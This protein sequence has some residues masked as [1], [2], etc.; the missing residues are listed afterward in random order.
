[1][2]SS[3]DDLDTSNKSPSNLN[4]QALKDDISHFKMVDEKK[5]EASLRQDIVKKDTENV[6]ATL[7]AILQKP[8]VEINT[9]LVKFLEKRWKDNQGTFLAYTSIPTAPSTQLCCMV[10][11]YLAKNIKEKSALVFLMPTIKYTKDAISQ[12]DLEKMPLE[13]VVRFYIT[14]TDNQSLI[15]IELLGYLSITSDRSSALDIYTNP[16]IL[17]KLNA[18]ERRRLRYH[19][20][21]TEDIISSFD[22]Y[23]Q[24]IEAGSSLYGAIEKLREGL[25]RGGEHGLQGGTGNEAGVFA[26]TA[27][28]QFREYWRLLTGTRDEVNANAAEKA[29]FADPDFKKIMNDKILNPK[30]SGECV[31][32]LRTDLQLILQKDNKDSEDKKSNRERFTA[33]ELSADKNKALQ[34]A[35][36]DKFTQAGKDLSSAV[37]SAAK[38]KLQYQGRD[39]LFLNVRQIKSM[40]SP[41]AISS[42][43]DVILILK[44]LTEEEIIA[45][46]SDGQE[47]KD[48]SSSELRSFK[49]NILQ[50]IKDINGLFTILLN[51]GDQQI[52]PF[53]QGIA[54]QLSKFTRHEEALGNGLNILTDS[55]FAA[56]LDAINNT[57]FNFTAPDFLNIRRSLSPTKNK[58]FLEKIYSRL[59]DMMI[60]CNDFKKIVKGL[61]AEKIGDFLVLQQNK[62]IGLAKEPW[63][64]VE[65]LDV[66]T[67]QNN[68][69]L[70]GMMAKNKLF[71]LTTSVDSFI[72]LINRLKD[73]Q[74][75]LYFELIKNQLANLTKKPADSVDILKNANLTAEQKL[76][77]L[78]SASAK[79]VELTDNADDFIKILTASQSLVLEFIESKNEEKTNTTVRQA[80]KMKSL[81][82]G[83]IDEPIRNK[84]FNL[85]KSKF[86]NITHDASDFNLILKNLHT[87]ESDIFFTSVKTQFVG[88]I[89]GSKEFENI[90]DVLNDTQKEIFFELIKTHL[91]T[92]PPRDFAIILKKLNEIQRKTFCDLI[93]SALFDKIVRDTRFDDAFSALMRLFPDKQKEIYFNLMQDKLVELTTNSK[94]FKDIMANLTSLQRAVY[95]DL[96]KNTKDKFIVLT[97]HPG[98][99]ETIMLSSLTQEQKNIYF[100]IIKNKIVALTKYSSDIEMIMPQLSDEQSKY[101]FDQIKDKLYV[102]SYKPISDFSCIFKSLKPLQK[103]EFFNL[104][105]DHF[106]DWTRTSKMAIEMFTLFNTIPVLKASYTEIIKKKLPSFLKRNEDFEIL[107]QLE[108]NLQNEL[109][110][111]TKDKLDEYIEDSRDFYFI[112]RQLAPNQQDEL[113]E[114][115]KYKLYTFLNNSGDFNA[116]MK[117][118]SPALRNKCFNEFNHK[119]PKFLRPQYDRP[120]ELIE[121]LTFLS[122][123]Q[124]EIFSAQIKGKELYS[125]ASWVIQLHNFKEFAPNAIQTVMP[126]IEMYLVDCV[127]NTDDYIQISANLLTESR[128]FYDACKAKLLQFSNEEGFF[129]SKFN[130]LLNAIPT[131]KCLDFL[132]SIQDKLKQQDQLFFN[133]LQT[134]LFSLLQTPEDFRKIMQLLTHPSLSIKKDFL[135]EL[136]DKKK[137]DQRAFPLLNEDF[138]VMRIISTRGE[139]ELKPEKEDKDKKMRPEPPLS[140][141]KLD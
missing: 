126:F 107:G 75:S 124:R 74:K 100:E 15:P 128:R 117:P 8:E 2:S 19:S 64:V 3:R 134:K 79:I 55:A 59:P 90:I 56:L 33:I 34:Q 21:I 122:P 114:L 76:F 88:L 31:Q 6:L 72:I 13:Q 47:E 136:S 23:H 86:N 30:W 25:R 105:K 27:L 18:D 132:T 40:V 119:L 50:G 51:L 131:E 24:I 16:F 101:F 93:D 28:D 58:V 98:D 121:I 123:E 80:D 22:E 125:V 69:D 62:I 106:D 7:K 9:A 36:I 133:T 1:M 116:I 89:K 85:I 11:E 102:S 108:P 17:V 115:I 70:F 65:I 46:F 77:Y 71:E 110:Q 141:K 48:S 130:A 83:K 10:A 91:L 66:L 73:A 96:V 37:E 49:F 52:S 44:N 139:V 111:L 29:A 120:F 99:F 42:A 92:L 63:D 78:T 38:S 12:T 84:Y 60:S 14:S 54:D 68:Q 95:F 140:P 4:L 41:E 87:A 104:M 43:D 20:N 129:Q 45:I 112:M 61:P 26:Y 32:S 67:G 109:Y 5:E 94:C 127:Q 82:S 135:T 57:K 137:K 39:R 138:E 103:T 113:Y 53:I 35:K 81:T 97:P 118:L